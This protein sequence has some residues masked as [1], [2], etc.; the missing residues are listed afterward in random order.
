L[1][2]LHHHALLL[3]MHVHLL[4]RR[5]TRPLLEALPSCRCCTGGR[6]SLRQ[7]P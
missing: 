6:A 5:H 4:H 7:R 3:L 2:L 1:L